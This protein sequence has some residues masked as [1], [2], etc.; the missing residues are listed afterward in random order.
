MPP[1]AVHRDSK[2]GVQSLG[3][4]NHTEIE[5]K[6]GL[7]LSLPSCTKGEEPKVSNAHAQKL[8]QIGGLG[9]DKGLEWTK[10]A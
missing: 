4:D 8:A 7:G 1:S 6:K 2:G 10:E 3:G 5:A 9:R